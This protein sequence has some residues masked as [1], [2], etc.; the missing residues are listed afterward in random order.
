MGIFDD[1]ECDV[2]KTSPYF[3]QAV[4]G[5]NAARDA[6]AINSQDDCKTASQIGS[7]IAEQ[8]GIPS[9]LGDS[10]GGCVCQYV[11][12]G[13]ASNPPGGIQQSWNYKQVAYIGND[14]HVW[15]LTCNAGNWTQGDLTAAAGAPPPAAGSSLT[16]YIWNAYKQVAYIG[17]DGHVWELTCNTGNWTQGDLTAAAGAPPPAAGSS[18]TS[19][20]WNAY[21]QVAYIGNDGHVWELT[22]SGA[23]SWSR[24][25]LTAATGAPPPAAGSSLTS[26]IWNTYKQVAYIGNDG[27]VWELTCTAGGN[28]S[29]GDLVAVTGSPA[30]A[31]DSP[32]T[33]YIWNDGPGQDPRVSAKQVAYLTSDRHI[34]ELTCVAGNWTEGDLAALTGSRT[35]A[36]GSPLTSYIWK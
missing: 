26:Y 16:S 18:L 19:Y 28:W 27:H 32:L 34:W 24:G 17:N 15:E 36:I 30:A 33:S 22:C 25:D 23:G 20:I 3:W 1:L 13:G 9:F 8:Y 5:V 2:W 31:G 29:N 7:T 6:H 12:S 11:F 14:G 10:F 21:K 4:V 35:A